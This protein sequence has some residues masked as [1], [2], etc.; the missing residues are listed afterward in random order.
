MV[1]IVFAFSPFALRL[2]RP[3]RVYTAYPFFTSCTAVWFSTKRSQR[4][5]QRMSRLHSLAQ[6]DRLK[7]QAHTKGRQC[8]HPS[9]LPASVLRTQWPNEGFDD[10]AYSR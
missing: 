3:A 1:T 5:S 4:S 9:T 8:R 7:A 2:P 6:R 10:E